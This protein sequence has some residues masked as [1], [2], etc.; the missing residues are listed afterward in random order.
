MD[1]AQFE[2]DVQEGSYQLQIQELNKKIE[3]L[4]KQIKNKDK[5][6]K[7]LKTTYSYSEVD[8]GLSPFVGCRKYNLLSETP[9]SV[10]YEVYI[11]PATR[12]FQVTDYGRCSIED[13]HRVG[14]TVELFLRDQL[15]ERVVKWHIESS[16]ISDT[17]GPGL[18]CYASE[19]IPK[20]YIFL[21]PETLIK[22]YD[23]EL[24]V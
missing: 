23:W 3:Y 12:K 16:H 19:S 7:E 4:N 6:L 11:K 21:H 18:K 2:N 5:E 24:G 10:D 8:L 1:T 17:F 9:F 22:L 15:L 20:G 13:L 14:K